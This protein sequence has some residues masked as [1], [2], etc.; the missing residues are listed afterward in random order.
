MQD[1]PDCLLFI[2]GIRTGVGPRLRK[3]EES[4]YL[5]VYGKKV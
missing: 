5:K 4:R 1:H 2:E 3:K